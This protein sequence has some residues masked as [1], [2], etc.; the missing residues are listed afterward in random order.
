MTASVGTPLFRSPEQLALQRYDTSADVWAAGCVLACLGRDSKCPYSMES[1][2]NL[3]G[4]I[5]RG[6]AQPRLEKRSVLCA[7]VRDCCQ[8]KVPKRISA[9]ELAEA[10]A[11]SLHALPASP[12]QT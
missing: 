12:S 6:E 9:G 5:V 7:A 8:L 4:Q 11:R 3:L 10:L 1:T 2:E